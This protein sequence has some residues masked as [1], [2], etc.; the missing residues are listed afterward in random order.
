[1]DKVATLRGLDQFQMACNQSGSLAVFYGDANA[2]EEKCGAVK[3]RNKQIQQDY[4]TDHYAKWR[5]LSVATQTTKLT[6]GQNSFA[7]QLQ[8]LE[9]R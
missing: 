6:A 5:P 2:S 4:R 9:V 1:M 3:L 7:A 8:K